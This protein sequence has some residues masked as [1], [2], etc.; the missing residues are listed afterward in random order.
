MLMRLNNKADCCVHRVL[1]DVFH[2][3]F[4]RTAKVQLLLAT[5]ERG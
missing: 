1:I 3:L 4:V 2:T 5:M